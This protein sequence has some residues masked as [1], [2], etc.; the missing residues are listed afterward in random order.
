MVFLR[1]QY[2][3]IDFLDV[4]KS[5]SKISSKQQFVISYFHQCQ[6]NVLIFDNESNIHH[7]TVKSRPTDPRNCSHSP[8]CWKRSMDTGPWEPCSETL[9]ACGIA[10]IPV[11][12]VSCSIN[13]RK[14]SRL[15]ASKKR[16]RKLLLQSFLLDFSRRSRLLASSPMVQL[17]L[18]RTKP[19]SQTPCKTFLG[20]LLLVCSRF[21]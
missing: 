2:L 21:G 8:W 18:C 3:P 11:V 15:S 17:G 20:G 10:T 1:S 19:P 4:S 13:F 9:K 6:L 12:S 14:L 7:T 5:M 16:S